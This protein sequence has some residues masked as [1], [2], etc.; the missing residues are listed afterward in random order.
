MR[1]VLYTLLIFSSISL[2]AGEEKEKPDG[3]GIGGGGFRSLEKNH[4]K[5]NSIELS[6]TSY[7]SQ[8]KEGKS[9]AKACKGK[10]ASSG[11]YSQEYSYEGNK[12]CL[13]LSC[14][15]NL[16]K[17]ELNEHHYTFNICFHNDV[18]K[19]IDSFEEAQR[20]CNTDTLKG[21]QVVWDKEQQCAKVHCKF[22]IEDEAGRKI[23]SSLETDDL[24][25]PLVMKY[26]KSNRSTASKKKLKLNKQ[27]PYLKK[28]KLDLPSV[29]EPVNSNSSNQ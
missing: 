6:N 4:R 20:N 8:I 28:K 3:T 7:Q 27:S 1:I 9:Y 18:Y 14:A 29:F 26:C 19:K 25:S 17:H 24:K 2:F 22:N 15:E 10:S 5:P 16:S 21:Y 11:I 13:K 12:A 23:I